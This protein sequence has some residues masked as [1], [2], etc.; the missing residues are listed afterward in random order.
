MCRSTQF[1]LTLS[2]PPS[3]HFACGGVHSSTVSHGLLHVSSSASRDQ[4]LCGSMAASSTSRLVCTRAVARNAGGGGTIAVLLQQDVDIAHGG[5]SRGGGRAVRSAR[6]T[7]SIMSGRVAGNRSA[8]YSCA[9]PAPEFASGSVPSEG[10]SSHLPTGHVV[11]RAMR[12][13]RA[14]MT[15]SPSPGPAPERSH[16]AA[17]DAADRCSDRRDARGDRGGPL[18]DALRSVGATVTKFR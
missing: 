7:R 16:A 3:N 5:V 15:S 2:S 18:A 9:M 13:E 10:A 6:G 8:D 17:S 11:L 12:R 1:T 14:R 4:K